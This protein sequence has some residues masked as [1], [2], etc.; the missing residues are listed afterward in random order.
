[1]ILVSATNLFGRRSSRNKLW[2]AQISGSLGLR[3]SGAG[4]VNGWSA[5]STFQLQPSKSPMPTRT[6]H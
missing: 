5:G 1:M 2:T 4:N 6:K 3:P